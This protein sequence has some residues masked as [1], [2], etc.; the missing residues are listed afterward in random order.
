MARTG[1]TV[2]PLPSAG[3]PGSAPTPPHLP[4][5]RLV[6]RFLRRPLPLLRLPQPP[7]RRVQR[8]LP[9]LRVRLR[10]VSCGLERRHTSLEHHHLALQGEDTSNPAPPRAARQPLHCQA[11]PFMRCLTSRRVTVARLASPA[12]SSSALSHRTHAR[13][14]FSSGI[15]C[16]SLSLWSNFFPVTLAASRSSTVRPST[17]EICGGSA[18]LSAVRSAVRSQGPRHA[19]AL[20]SSHSSATAAPFT[21]A[22]SHDVVWTTAA[23]LFGAGGFRGVDCVLGTGSFRFWPGEAAGP[24]AC[25]SGSDGLRRVR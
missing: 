17:R 24:G 14:F 5:P 3:F 2:S 11:L 16:A 10:L 1:H 7:P 12:R 20:A 15:A 4:G 13:V 25:K 22:S 23:L 9:R 6:R 19:A 21:G 18:G 8:L